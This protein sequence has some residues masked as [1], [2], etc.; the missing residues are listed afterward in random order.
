V[1]AIVSTD[2]PGLFS[3]LY[4]T[5]NYG[6]G[7]SQDLTLSRLRCASDLQHPVSSSCSSLHHW[8]LAS[9]FGSLCAWK[10]EVAV[11]RG[12][13]PADSVLPRELAAT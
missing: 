4:C 2:N 9:P 7:P 10:C 8:A 6:A 1:G 5:K 3:S 13:Q 11:D 12:E